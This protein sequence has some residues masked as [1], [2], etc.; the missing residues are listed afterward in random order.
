MFTCPSNDDFFRSRIDHMID[1]RHLLAVLSSSMAWQQI[2]AS[3]SHLFMRKAR[4]GVAMPDLY[5]FGEAA[6]MVA[7]Q[8][9]AGRPRVLLRIMISR[10][11]LFVVCSHGSTLLD[12]CCT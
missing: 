12:R 10:A 7:P 8:R 5:L 11:K 9:N 1:L 6:P 2:E 4:S 3:L